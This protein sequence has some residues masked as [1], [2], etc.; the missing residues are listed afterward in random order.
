M[1]FTAARTDDLAVGLRRISGTFTAATYATNGV[2]IDLSGV[3]STKCESCIVMPGNA[4]TA[5]YV[6]ESIGFPSTTL[7]TAIKL[8]IYRPITTFYDNDNAAS[9][10][11]ALYVDEDDSGGELGQFVAPSN[12]DVQQL[13][14]LI[15]LPNS[16][17]IS[18]LSWN[19]E[20][21]GY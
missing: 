17:S 21:T 2:A 6:S 11:V 5:A 15:E 4:A 13:E 3:F 12:A 8:I 16:T 9:N 7:A 1:A 10:G 19:V 18:T 20:V 14:T